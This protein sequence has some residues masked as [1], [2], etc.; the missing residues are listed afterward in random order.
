MKRIS[1]QER[2]RHEAGKVV[3][4]KPNELSAGREGLLLEG[5]LVLDVEIKASEF[6][7]KRILTERI[8]FG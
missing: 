3:G 2:N 7:D 1:S 8:I 6:E 5:S 4:L